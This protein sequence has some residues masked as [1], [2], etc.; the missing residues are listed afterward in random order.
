MAAL[1]S[2]QT[3][4]T[5]FDSDRRLPI[6]FVFHAR[7]IGNVIQRH[8]RRQLCVFIDYGLALNHFADPIDNVS[9]R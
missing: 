6:Q 7:E 9:Q 5:L 1:L 8:R 3:S 4:Q 2:N